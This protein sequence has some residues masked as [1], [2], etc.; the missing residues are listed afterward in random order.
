MTPACREPLK[1][2][3]R[4]MDNGLSHSGTALH[5]LAAVPS[6]NHSCSSPHFTYPLFNPGEALAYGQPSLS[7]SLGVCQ[8]SHSSK[9]P[10]QAT[11]SDMGP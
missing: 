11:R 10:A 9:T 5:A 8:F 3:P 6:D 7:V 2:R 1:C 4:V